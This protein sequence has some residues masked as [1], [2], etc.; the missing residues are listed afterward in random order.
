MFVIIIFLLVKVY[1][2]VLIYGGTFTWHLARRTSEDFCRKKLFLQTIGM[3]EVVAF[4]VKFICRRNLFAATK[5]NNHLRLKT[6]S[7]IKI[8]SFTDI[9]AFDEKDLD[10]DKL[11]TI[12]AT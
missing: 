12:L 1:R 2:H 4:L 9:L 8:L 11:L 5:N 6:P 3:I 7:L 10:M